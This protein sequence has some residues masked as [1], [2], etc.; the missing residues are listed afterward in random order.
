K[1]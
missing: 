1:W